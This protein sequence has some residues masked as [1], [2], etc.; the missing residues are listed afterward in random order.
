LL[1]VFSCYYR[2]LCDA[3]I[4]VNLGE[5]GVYCPAGATRCTDGVKFGMEESTKGR[6][7]HTRF[8]SIGAGW[9]V[10][11]QKLLLFVHILEYKCPTGAY[12]FDNK[13]LDKGHGHGHMTDF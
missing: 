10:E 6:L 12:P 5:F 4:S 9:G 13:P 8:Y 7:L 3:S 1:L 11:P 2:Q